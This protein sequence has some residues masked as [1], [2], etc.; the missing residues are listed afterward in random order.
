MWKQKLPFHVM[1][2]CLWHAR[3]MECEIA[4][5]KEVPRDLGLEMQF[6]KECNKLLDF[7]Q[8]G[9][10]GKKRI[11]IGLAFFLL[12]KMFRPVVQQAASLLLSYY[13]QE[14][15]LYLKDMTFSF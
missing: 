1:K 13:H 8:L 10:L 6:Q 2:K 15:A 5:G 11:L 14:Q 12:I 3:Q 4:S 9:I 7:R